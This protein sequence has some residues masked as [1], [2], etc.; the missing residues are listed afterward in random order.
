M[1][2][3]VGAMHRCDALMGAACVRC[4]APTASKGMGDNQ[5]V[6]RDPSIPMYIPP[7]GPPRVA[8]PSHEIYTL[9]GEDAIFLMMEEFYRELEQSSL[10]IS[11]CCSTLAFT[12][13]GCG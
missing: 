5:R 8:L 4:I 6:E 13:N 1:V 11:K 2:F 3:I 10:L 12:L 9:M 7:G